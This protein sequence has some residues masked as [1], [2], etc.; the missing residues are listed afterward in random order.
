MYSSSLMWE[1]SIPIENP[2]LIIPTLINGILAISRSFGDM[3]FKYPYNKSMKDFVSPIPALQMTPIGKNNPYLIVTCDGLY[4]KMDYDE[5]LDFFVEK[6]EEG[7]NAED[8]AKA[9]TNVAYERG[10]RDNCSC[11]VVLLNWS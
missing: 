5:V 7:L 2:I 11:I 8:T 3:E 6:L 4:E 10:S 9:L 1:E